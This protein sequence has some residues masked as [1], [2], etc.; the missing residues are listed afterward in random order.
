MTFA[1][2]SRAPLYSCASGEHFWNAL[3]HDRKRTLCVNANLGETDRL[4]WATCEGLLL[5]G[6][7]R[8]GASAFPRSDDASN[9]DCV[10]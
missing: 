9:A 5:F 6:T 3:L 2:F 1:R 4:G 10:S 7:L 8:S